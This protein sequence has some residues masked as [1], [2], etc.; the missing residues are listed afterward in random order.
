MG[1]VDSHRQGLHAPPLRDP[2][3]GDVRQTEAG[4]R[5]HW[6]KRHS[7]LQELELLPYQVMDIGRLTS[8]EAGRL[9]VLAATWRADA[10]L[11]EGPDGPTDEYLRDDDLLGSH[12]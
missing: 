12:F 4:R 6:P 9:S 11:L 5:A 10:D 8:V 1:Y 3:G 2:R 7:L